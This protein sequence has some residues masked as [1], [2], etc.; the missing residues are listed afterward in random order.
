MYSSKYRLRMI[1]SYSHPIDCYPL[2]AP[3]VQIELRATVRQAVRFVAAP[4][5]PM[6]ALVG[7]LCA[8]ELLVLCSHDRK[9]TRSTSVSAN[10]VRR[11][12]RAG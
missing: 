11:R 3:G 6:L 1:L 4:N 10:F 9:P 2:L 12:P 7:L 8:C 5:E